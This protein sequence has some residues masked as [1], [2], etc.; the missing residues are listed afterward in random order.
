MVHI[1]EENNRVALGFYANYLER[2]SELLVEK[3]LLARAELDALR[4]AAGQA[5]GVARRDIW[6]VAD[7][8]EL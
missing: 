2:F 7:V 6:R 3:G 4:E 5:P 1:E 8:D